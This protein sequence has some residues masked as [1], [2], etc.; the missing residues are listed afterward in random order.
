MS[1]ERNNKNTP[2]FGQIKLINIMKELGYNQGGEGLCFGIASM[3]MQ[4]FLANGLDK[5][6]ERITAIHHIATL[7]QFKSIK[8]KLL[9]QESL[10]DQIT[11]NNLNIPL[12]EILAFLDGIELYQFP[13][14]HKKILPYYSRQESRIASEYLTP[15]NIDKKG[16]RPKYI[17]NLCGAYNKENLTILLEQLG[18]RLKSPSS[19]LLSSYNHTINLN[20]APQYNR[21]FLIN[22]NKLPCESFLDLS[23]LSQAI[24]S[25]F[26]METKGT[27]YTIFDTIFFTHQSNSK[28]SKNNITE[29]STSEEYLNLK[30][31]SPNAEDSF[32]NTLLLVACQNGRTEVVSSLLKIGANA[33]KTASDETTPLYIASQNGFIKIILEL[34]KAGADINKTTEDGTTPLYIASQNGH[35]E[36]V[37]ALLQNGAKAN[38]SDDDRITPLFIASQNGHTEVV[39]TLLQN[40]AKANMGDLEGATPLY[41]A[42][43]N[44]HIEVVRELLKYKVKYSLSNREF[45]PLDI[46]KQNGHSAIVDLISSH[47]ANEKEKS[48]SINKNSH[49][50]FQSHPQNPS[51]TKT[52]NN[53][54]NNRF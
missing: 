51:T 33:N 26:N 50:L 40:G 6:I 4:A 3:A 5:F 38:K 35:T 30:C 39:Q 12:W 19:L 10:D 27:G 49:T 2:S 31:L 34:I 44:G 25:A 28:N 23:K 41:M 37:Q 53:K 47:I 42:S 16:R 36:V 15:V 46:A 7:H 29:L 14:K 20:Y 8:D 54:T 17:D 45:N 52:K 22:A 43:K 11:V 32:G 13:S 18:S 24:I 1:N 21:W 48:S 9:K